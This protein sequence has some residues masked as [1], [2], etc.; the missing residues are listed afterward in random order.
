MAE[1]KLKTRATDADVAAFLEAVPDARRRAEGRALDALHRQ[2]A[3]C[4]P[5]MW[6]PS[7]VGYGRYA[8][9]YDSGREGVAPRAGFSPRKAAAVVYLNGDLGGACEAEAAALFARLGPHSS[10]KC[11]LYLKRLDRIDLAALEGLVRLSWQ[12]MNARYPG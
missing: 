6:G 3:G 11:C 10:G 2:V 8:Y 1:A 7:I 4:A 9:R 12:A 5:R